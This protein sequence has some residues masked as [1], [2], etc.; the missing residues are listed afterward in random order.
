MRTLTSS[1]R[2]GF[3][4][5]E[6]LVV[7]A[8]IAILIGLLLPAVQKVREAAARSQCRNNMKQIALAVLNYEVTKKALP[9]AGRGYGWCR[10]SAGYPADAQITNQNGLVYV[11]P[12][13][14]QSAL[15]GKFVLNQAFAN[16]LS[17]TWSSTYWPVGQNPQDIPGNALA[18]N[19]VTNGNGALASTQLPVFRCPSDGGDP[20]MPA[21]SPYGPG[22]SLTGV[23]TNYDFIVREWE[24]A[25]CNSW[26]S[27]GARRY[28]FGQNSDC[29]IAQVTDGMSNTFMLG[30]TTYSVYNGTCP[31]WS[32][33]AWVMVGIDP[34]GWNVSINDWSW[35]GYI[36][37]PVV[38]RLG[39]WAFPGSMHS[40]GCQFALCSSSSPATAGRP[41]IP[42]P[43]PSR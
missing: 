1:R 25:Y 14:D 6:L 7:I 32:Y 2:R 34:A 23:K 17:N 29:R 12:Y 24:Y 20:I 22:G 39:S 33:R 10:V 36:A 28:M 4:L 9:P 27:D 40:S 43:E 35:G 38:G 8:I 3:T 31:T 41:C 15:Y 42:F 16:T 21:S 11:L 19:A 37:T 18:G 30:E 26:R 5:I 13:L